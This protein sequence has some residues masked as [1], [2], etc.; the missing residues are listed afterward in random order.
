MENANIIGIISIVNLII[1]IVLS[2]CGIYGFVL[3]IKLAKRGIKAL[4]IYISEKTNKL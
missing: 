3:F 1:I 4:D 2:G